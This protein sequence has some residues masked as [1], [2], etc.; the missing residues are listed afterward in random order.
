MG[1]II[2]KKLRIEK[3]LNRYSVLENM[4]QQE[5]AVAQQK[6]KKEII[7]TKEICDNKKDDTAN[8][9]IDCDDSD[10]QFALGSS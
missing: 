1:G 10:C 4:A 8:G 3:L 6:I 9:K 2:M 7:P 5:L